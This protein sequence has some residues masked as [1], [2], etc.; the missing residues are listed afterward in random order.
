MAVQSGMKTTRRP[1]SSQSQASGDYVQETAQQATQV[2]GDAIE[3]VGEQAKQTATTQKER[4]VGGLDATAHAIRETGQSVR[5]QQ[6]MVAEYADKA[7]EGVERVSGYLRERDVDEVIQDVQDYARRNKGIFIGGTL[8]LGFM[9]ARLIKAGGRRQQ[10]SM[11][12]TTTQPV[13]IS[14]SRYVPR[15]DGVREIEPLNEPYDL[16]SQPMVSERVG[17]VSRTR[18]NGN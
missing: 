15:G 2:A 4:I 14:S 12:T 17:S 16:P 3:K 8:L 7:A 6:P 1:S 9:A 11:V 18:T 13:G 10:S 5:Q